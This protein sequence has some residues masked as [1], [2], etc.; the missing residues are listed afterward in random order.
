MALSVR[1]TVGTVEY[2]NNGSPYLTS[3]TFASVTS[4]LLVAGVMYNGQGTSITSVKNDAGVSFSA[5]PGSKQSWS[6][7][8]YI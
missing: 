3:P 7:S 6:G 2:T 4:D 1:Y 8:T 5:I